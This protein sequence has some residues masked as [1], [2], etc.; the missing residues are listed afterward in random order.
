MPAA[1]RSADGAAQGAAG[2]A[3]VSLGALYWEDGHNA[4]RPTGPGAVPWDGVGHVS[5]WLSG[6]PPR[7][8]V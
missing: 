2:A 8:L 7:S 6:M 3:R 1:F 4:A 5:T